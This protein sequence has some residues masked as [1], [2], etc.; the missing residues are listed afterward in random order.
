MPPDV[1]AERD[2]RSVRFEQPRGVQAAR[3]LEDSLP[4]SERVGQSRQDCRGNGRP[5]RKDAA[6]H[7][8]LVDRRL[9]AHAAARGGV[10]VPLERT[11]VERSRQAHRDH[12]VELLGQVGLAVPDRGDLVAALDQPL[13]EQEPGGQLEVVPGG[14]HRDGHALGLLPEPRHLDLHRLLGG[15][16]VGAL[17]R[18]RLANGQ[19]PRRRGVVPG[20]GGFHRHSSII[21]PGARAISSPHGGARGRGGTGPRRSRARARAGRACRTARRGGSPRRVRRP[22]AHRIDR[23]AVRPAAVRQRRHGRVRRPVRRPGRRVARRARGPH[24]RGRRVRR[25]RAPGTH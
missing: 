23:R 25:R 9:P 16:P 8:H 13:G 22:G 20:S 24:H 12:V 4:R 10:E 11:G 3:L 1:L 18:P 6:R 15:Q 17:R 21:D 14:S 7:L 5:R 19:Q 2:R